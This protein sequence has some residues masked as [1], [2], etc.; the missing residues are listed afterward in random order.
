MGSAL[1]R[2][3]SMRWAL[4]CH[5]MPHQIPPSKFHVSISREVSRSHHSS[6]GLKVPVQIFIAH[7]RGDIQQAAV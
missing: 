4:N 1:N 5:R 6:R 2:S 3:S 7:L